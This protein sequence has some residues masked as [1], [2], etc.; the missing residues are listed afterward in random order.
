MKRLQ[1]AGPAVP[2]PVDLFVGPKKN[3]SWSTCFHTCPI[4]SAN[5]GCIYISYF[6]ANPYC[7]VAWD[8]ATTISNHL[9]RCAHLI[10]LQ[11][12]YHRVEHASTVTYCQRPKKESLKIYEWKSSHWYVWV[13]LTIGF[14]SHWFISMFPS[15]F[16]DISHFKT[17]PHRNLKICI[18]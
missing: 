10:D 8:F 13:C 15:T 1:R 6:W 11:I 3:N 17:H 12:S 16:E 14:T 2:H 5:L 9:D 7:V 18:R 4:G